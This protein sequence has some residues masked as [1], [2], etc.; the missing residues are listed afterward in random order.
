MNSPVKDWRTE[1]TSWLSSNPKRS[2][3][4]LQQL[5]EAFVQRF[6]REQLSDLTL[7][8][9]AIGKPDSFCYWLEFKTRSLGSVSG[10]SSSKW[11]IWWSKGD[12]EWKWNK[13]FQCSDP[14]DAFARI[15]SGLVSLTNAAASDHFDQLEQI[16]SSQLGLNRNGLRAKPLYLYFPDKFLPISNPY[17]LA[18]FLNFFGQQPAGGLHAKNH[19]LLNF[20]KGQPEFNGMDT[21]QM[22]AFLYSAIPPGD[23]V[24][25]PPSEPESVE[26]VQLPEEIVQL[27]TLTEET[28]N[29]ILYGPPGTG[30]TY[31]VNK[32][33][34]FFLGEQLTT[35]L[36]P[37]QQRREILQPLT[38]HDAIALAM[39][40]ERPKKYFKVPE[41]V[42]NLLIQEY[43]TLTKTQK[44]SNQIWAML[45][46]HTHPDVETVKYKNRQPPYLFEKNQ[47]GEWSLTEEGEGYIEVNLA[48]TL[49][50]LQ[51]PDARKPIIS[52]YL[53]FVTF[54]QSFAYEEFVEG[55]KP[56]IVDGQIQ[57]QVVDGIFKGI[58]RQAQ[59][60]PEHRYLIIIDEINRANI[61]KVFGELITLIE[62]DKRLGED[63]EITVRLPY[64]QEEFG[65]PENV[66]ILGTMNTAD[67]SIALLDIALRR[68]FTFVELLPDPSLLTTVEGIDLSALLTRLNQCITALL[69]RDYQI[70]HSYFINVK[71]V[72]ELHFAWYRRV[73]PLLQE[74]FY[75]DAE[76][77]RAVLGDRFIQ[78]KEFDD[79]TKKALKNLC[80][81]DNQYIIKV[82]E[83]GDEF[84]QVLQKTFMELKQN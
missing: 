45:Q 35:P 28:R 12:Q 76:R 67:R 10:G 47:Q 68:R 7:E 8:E 41:L 79:Y 80:D 77:L 30:K 48:D 59:N 21:L 26:R 5:R 49:D 24:S 56:V 74:Y 40:L 22:M 4:D 64:S 16:G 13:A 54:H 69:G 52:D 70:G 46:I 32:F 36:A 81:F 1:L 82:F 11:G 25:K 83:P 20:L 72:T 33:A 37:E 62:D 51:Q 75:N 19:Q 66:Y 42:N 14:K 18:H 27:A 23:R 29:L 73:I 78:P 38:W 3:S 53:R 6:P 2:P 15:R 34:S 50:D 58:C 31:A 17:H 57:Y 63:S 65:V 43:L 55:L 60:D 9:Y 61:A 44:L 84:L 39:Y 71:D